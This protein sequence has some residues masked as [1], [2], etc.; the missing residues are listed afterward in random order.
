MWHFTCRVKGLIV[1]LECFGV[2][3]FLFSLSTEHDGFTCTI[4]RQ[5]DRGRDE[6]FNIYDAGR[7][8][9]P[10]FPPR[11]PPPS[12]GRLGLLP[13]IYILDLRRRL[14]LDRRLSP[15]SYR[16]IT[17]TGLGAG[18]INNTT[19]PLAR[20][21]VPFFRGPKLLLQ[22]IDSYHDFLPPSQT[23]SA[24]SFD[25][26]PRSAAVKRQGLGWTSREHS[27]RR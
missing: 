7:M 4:S 2:D 21:S 17:Q 9:G 16:T 25:G 24:P 1:L 5:L 27:R 23:A 8:R 20:P 26:S 19:P 6:F 18:T 11:L 13:S 10:S 12:T 14:A 22:F 3:L 15:T